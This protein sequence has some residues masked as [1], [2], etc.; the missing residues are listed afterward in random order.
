MTVKPDEPDIEL[1]RGEVEIIPPGQ[2]ARTQDS[3]PFGFETGP[4]ARAF[5]FT[6]RSGGLLS[7]ILVA[8]GV[9]ALFALLLGTFAVVAGIAV[10]LFAG[11]YL[12]NRLMRWLGR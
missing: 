3:G 11:F 10:M 4:R 1:P 5:L 6:S 2:R 9:A 12:R 8:L 7:A